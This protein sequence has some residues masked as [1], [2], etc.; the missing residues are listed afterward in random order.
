M[1]VQRC[2]NKVVDRVKSTFRDT[3]IE[4]FLLDRGDTSSDAVVRPAKER[5]G[6]NSW[7]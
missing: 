6:M 5:A 2:L 7:V 3:R 1:M 4:N